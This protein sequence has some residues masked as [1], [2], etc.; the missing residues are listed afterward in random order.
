LRARPADPSSKQARFGLDHRWL[1]CMN[2]PAEY[3]APIASIMPA[4]AIGDGEASTRT[5]EAN[6]AALGAFMQNG[7]PSQT[8]D[9]GGLYG[10]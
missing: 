2:W 8:D 1:D 7:S 4:L 10:D 3:R 9:P 5:A 6:G